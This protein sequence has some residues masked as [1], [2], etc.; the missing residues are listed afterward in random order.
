MTEAQ[1]RRRSAAYRKGY[2]DGLAAAR[3]AFD[4]I[5]PAQEHLAIQFCNEIAGPLGKPGCPPDPVRLLEM[6]EALYRAEVGQ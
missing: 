1:K 4:A 6:A 5:A 2:E 3:P